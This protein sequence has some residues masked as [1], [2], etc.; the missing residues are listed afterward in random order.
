MIHV[1]LLHLETFSSPQKEPLKLSQNPELVLKYSD[2]KYLKKFF[3]MSNFSKR[4]WKNF[5]NFKRCKNVYSIL[6][7]IL[8]C[9]ITWIKLKYKQSEGRPTR[10]VL[11]GQRMPKTKGACMFVKQFNVFMDYRN[12]SKYHHLV[13]KNSFRIVLTVFSLFGK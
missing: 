12:A 9:I 6:K 11:T 8:Q 4:M 2:L 1:F 10:L 7:F 13:D 3:D 5:Q